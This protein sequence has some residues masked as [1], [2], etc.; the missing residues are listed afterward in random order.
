MS[1]PL[2]TVICLCYNHEKYLLEAV[3]SITDQSYQNIEI[4]I[5][6]NGSIDNSQKLI[7]NLVSEHPGIKMNLLNENLGNCRAFN[8]G[9]SES[10]GEYIIDLSADD[11]LLPDRIEEG[12][13]SFERYGLD[14]GV[15]FTDAIY[16]DN[17]GKVLGPHYKRDKNGLLKDSVPEG[18]VYTELLTRY[19][20]CT[21][22]MMMRK[23]VLDH[24]GGYDESLSYEDFDFWVRSGKITKYCYT[25]KILVKKRLLKNSLSSSQYKKNS[26]MLRS[27]FLVC[28][29][30][31][32]LNETESETNALRSRSKYEF[33]KAFFSGNLREAYQFSTLFIRNSKQGLER[34]LFTLINSLLSLA[35]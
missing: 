31:E 23:S 12:I 24:L 29:K 16:I 1:P 26:H 10:E 6:D 2:V 9:L 33:R 13:K 19:F 21:P 5:V 7:K 22:T 3:N 14:Y 17:S 32:K 35:R 28:L 34:F 8:I 27:T 15:N 4:I 11:V 25:D 20:I 18:N 30:A